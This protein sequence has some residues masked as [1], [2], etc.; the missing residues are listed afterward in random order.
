MK[1]LKICSSSLAISEFQIKTA[2]R[3]H[4]TLIKMTKI[5]KQTKQLT[6]NAGEDVGKDLSF[7]LGGKANWFSCSEISVEDPQQAKSRSTTPRHMPKGHDITFHR[8][9]L[10]YGHFCSTHNSQAMETTSVLLSD[11]WIIKM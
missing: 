1:Y 6:T 10:S 2:L 7:L 5:T 9:L 4:L 8:H 11:K 3:F